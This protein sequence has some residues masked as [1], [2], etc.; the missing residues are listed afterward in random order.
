MLSPCLIKATKNYLILL[1]QEVGYA[2]DF[3]K[4]GAAMKEQGFFYHC[5]GD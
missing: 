3:V 5:V 2:C 4:S 1:Y